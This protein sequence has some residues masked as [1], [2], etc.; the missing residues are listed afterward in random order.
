MLRHFAKQV[1]N[2]RAPML[3][4]ATTPARYY[5]PDGGLITRKVGQYY[6]DPH[7]VAE[8]VV[9]IIALHDACRDPSNITTSMTFEEL[10][11]NPLDMVEVFLGIERDL[12]IE[13]ACEDCEA[14]HTVDDIVEHV[15]RNSATIL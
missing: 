9:R 13:I 2:V 8:R 14:M 11:F 4:S 10:G 6:S 3:L 12:D 15:A 7:E 1:S 5:T